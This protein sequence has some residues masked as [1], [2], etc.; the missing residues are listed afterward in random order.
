MEINLWVT[1]TTHL[2]AT[3]KILIH[4]EADAKMG[5]YYLDKLEEKYYI[6]SDNIKIKT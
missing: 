4:R 2:F 6:T 5:L 1:G 3:I